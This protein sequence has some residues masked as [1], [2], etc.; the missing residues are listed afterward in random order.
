MNDRTC[1]VTRETREPDAL[2]R[3]VAAPDR[4]IVPEIKRKLPGRG[5]WVTAER[6]FVDEAARKNLFRKGLKSD[7]AVSPE[8]G[9]MVDRVLAQNALGALGLAR[10]AGAV[11]LGAAK[12]EAAVRGGAALAVLHAAEAQ[13][14]GMRKIA[15]GRRATAR[16]GGPDIPAYKLF[17]EAE[18]GLALGGL[19]VIH[20][21]LLAG[22][23]GNA[24]LKR[25]V[26]LDRYRGGSPEDGLGI[27]AI[28]SVD[29]SFKD[30]E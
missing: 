7:V 26:A 27:G 21:A 11:V 4:S 1:I 22:D 8:L 12:V 2:I 19:S 16:L 13:P 9:A 25:V 30:M 6:R 17:S 23:A 24:A 14:D 5:C 28:E 3:F 29:G 18:L 20:A 15:Q 10:K